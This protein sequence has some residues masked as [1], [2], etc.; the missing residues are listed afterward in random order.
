[1]AGA[2]AGLAGSA[3][4]GCVESEVVDAFDGLLEMEAGSGS[5][6]KD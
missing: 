2:A 4:G 6:P 3:I 1:M 5:S